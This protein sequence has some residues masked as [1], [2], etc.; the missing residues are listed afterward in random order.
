MKYELL[1]VCATVT[2]MIKWSMLELFFFCHKGREIVML[3]MA[4][5]RL[6]PSDTPGQRMSRVDSASCVR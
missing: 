1:I 3:C 6:P 5:P 2:V 4:A